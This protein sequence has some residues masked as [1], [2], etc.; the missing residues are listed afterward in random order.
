MK[1]GDDLALDRVERFMAENVPG[2]RGPLAAER[3]AGGHHVHQE[4]RRGP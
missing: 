2:F 1:A 3:F 4:A